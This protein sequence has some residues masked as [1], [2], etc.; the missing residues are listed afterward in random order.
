M[1]SAKAQHT[2][3]LVLGS[4]IAGLRAAIALAERGHVAILTKGDVGDPTT[5]SAHSRVPV[6][7]GEDEE[8]SLHLH[9]T[10]RAGEGL[11]REEAVRVLMEEGPAR[12]EELI[13]WESRSEGNGARLSFKRENSHGHARLLHA[14]GDS[15]GAEILRVLAAKVKSLAK[16]RVLPRCF[17]TE[18]LMDGTRVAGVRY[19]DGGALKELRAEATLLATGGLGQAFKD[20]T[21]PA[22]ASGDGAAMAWRAG[23][24]L[25]DME[26]VHF[27]PTALFIKGAPRI[28]LATALLDEGARLRNIDLDRFM[29]Q[30]HEAAELAPQDVLTRATFME[31][32]RMRSEFVYLDLTSLDEARLKKRFSKIYSTCMDYNIDIAA[33]LLPVRPAAHF[34]MGGVATDLDGSAT[35]DGLFAAGEVAATGLH[36]ANR[37]PGNTL[38]EGLVFGARAAAAMIAGKRAG[39]QPSGEAPRQPVTSEHSAIPN[40]A[41]AAAKPDLARLVSD[42]RCVMWK[43]VG[44]IRDGRQ[45][46]AAAAKLDALAFAST[47]SNPAEYEAQNILDISR[48]IA[49]S[50][51][52][53]HESRGAHYRSDYPLRDESAPPRHSFLSRNQPV[54]FE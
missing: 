47:G 17:A 4:S 51:L 37:L 21:N 10:L 2:D 15:T 40:G 44:I 9:D 52:A 12:T 20:T 27:C 28:L 43:N 42:V 26:F 50:A 46:A 39:H 38:L 18:L 49:R 1:T 48:A 13:H 24:L 32:E 14:H 30:H 36:G 11:C 45:L 7:L 16:I 41:P 3:F 22:I 23:A 5:R 8:V 54:Y 35:L 6:T 25:S 31:M 29:P 19:L 34:A 53:R 33:D